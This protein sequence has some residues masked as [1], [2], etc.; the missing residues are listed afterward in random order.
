MTYSEGELW[1]A[2]DV[3]IDSVKAKYDP[4]ISQALQSKAVRECFARE[5]FGALGVPAV[6]PYPP[7][8]AESLDREEWTPTDALRFYADGKHF[9]VVH[10]RTRIIDTGAIASN[11]L[12]HASLGYLEMKGDSELSD[13]RAANNKLD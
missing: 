13:L 4:E 6:P 1:A 5:L 7:E 12:K 10:G 2:I 9:D 8:I 3:A 11:A